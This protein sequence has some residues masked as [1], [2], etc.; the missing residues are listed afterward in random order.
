MA[1]K[2]NQP[3]SRIRKTQSGYNYLET[4]TKGIMA[5]VGTLGIMMI[6]GIIAHFLFK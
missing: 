1:Q 5:W 4:L 6:L 2:K 3:R